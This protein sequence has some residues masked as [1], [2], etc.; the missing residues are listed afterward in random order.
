[1]RPHSP[2]GSPL[3]SISERPIRIGV[4]VFTLGVCSASTMLMVLEVG[5]ILAS[6]WAALSSFFKQRAG[7]GLAPMGILAAGPAA[8]VRLAHR[9]RMI[10]HDGHVDGRIPDQAGILDHRP[11][12]QKDNDHE[13][14]HADE[15]EQPVVHAAAA[16]D[17]QRRFNQELHGAPGDGRDLLAMQ[18]MHD[19]GDNAQG[20][21][22]ADGEG[23]GA[24][25]KHC[26][27]DKK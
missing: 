20:G 8:A 3:E 12:Q 16:F 22:E 25:E 5:S 1:M 4:G 19:H 27:P 18:Q 13:D 10:D 7:R 6:D 21:G 23:D 17:P 2:R 14:G 11:A 15:H 26:D 9:Q 24:H